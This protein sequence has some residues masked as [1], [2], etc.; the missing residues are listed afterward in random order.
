MSLDPRTWRVL[1]VL[2]TVPTLL[3]GVVVVAGIVGIWSARNAYPYDLEWMEGG[4]LTH[5]WR[6]MQGK[7]THTEPQVDWVPYLYPTGYAS[8]LAALG[9]VFGLSMSM[10]R[11]VSTLGTVMA[12]LAM[13]YITHRAG[14][15]AIPGAIAATL[16]IAC[17]PFS[18]AFYDLVRL[19]GLMVGLWAWSLA[20]A[21][22]GRKGTIPAAGLLLAAAYLV[23]HNVAL[24]GFPIVIALWQRGGRREALTFALWAAIPALA[25]TVYL[26]VVN[27]GNYLTW[28]LTV[29]SSHNWA[30]KRI[31]PGIGQDHGHAM[32]LGCIAAT[33]AL[34]WWLR[35][36][37][38]AKVILAIA[39]A[40]AVISTAIVY[41][42]R[43]DKTVKMAELVSGLTVVFSGLLVVVGLLARQLRSPSWR[44]TLGV[45]VA[46]STLLMC[47]LMRGHVGGFVNVNIP[48]H[49]VLC[50]AAA[51]ALG[52][53]TA[54]SASWK[55]TAATA[56]VAV[57]LMGQLWWADSW[58]D[59][60]K[61]T[62]TEADV[63]AGDA[64]VEAL[65]GLPEPVLSPFNPWLLVLAGHEEPGWHLIALWDV[66]HARGPWPGSAQ[67][68][69]DAVTDQHWTYILEGNREL[70]KGLDESIDRRY[71]AGQVLIG[72]G[73]FRPKSGFGVYPMRL[74]P[75]R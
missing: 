51:G 29:P 11:T 67:M 71:G 52:N 38:K 54:L 69:D 16:F 58:I 63:A 21:V 40:A 64:L 45:G 4:M 31:F 6:L 28:L 13:P 65:T 75:R 70:S 18:G 1:R 53:P 43:L 20:F 22:D 61:L 17:Y 12:A 44:F 14:R 59:G 48:A 68:M 33:G 35:D 41:R 19:D 73:V 7:L 72:R 56:G 50:L 23:K 42:E 66:A 2:S 62:P 49:W 30:P 36:V 60:E 25:V 26:D 8:V 3:V 47:M 5:A 46:T 9:K 32:L 55:G 37:K 15:S 74:R 24:T 10:A 27:D 57:L 39:V 34:L